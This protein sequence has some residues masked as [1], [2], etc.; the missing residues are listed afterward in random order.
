MRAVV[1]PGPADPDASP[2]VLLGQLQ[3]LIGEEAVARWFADLLAG[4]VRYDD[5]ELP[6]LGWF[7]TGAANELQRG[8]LEARGQDYWVRT[9]A[10]RGLLHGWSEGA[11]DVAVPAIVGALD[12]DAWRVREMA[13]KVVRRWRLHEAAAGVAALADDEVPRVRAA[14]A[15]ARSELADAGAA[16]IRR[17]GSRTTS[18]SAPTPAKRQPPAVATRAPITVDDLEAAVTDAVQV[19]RRG[20]DLDWSVPAGTLSWDCRRTCAHMADDL[21]AYAAQ[22]AAQ[23]SSGYLPFRLQPSRGT[24]PEGL[25]N[26]VE[27]TGAILAA[28]VRVAPEGAR[29][30]HPYGIADAEGFTALGIAEVILHTHDIAAGLG[31]AYEPAADVC[32]RV[33]SRLSRD[34]Q[35]RSESPWS[36][37]LWA[38]GRGDLPGREPVKRWRW[39][40]APAR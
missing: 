4:R 29:G 35:A 22:L 17:Q 40:P 33:L 14:A 30:F 25:L 9:W 32:E 7:G 1:I 26:L 23:V 28:T 3:E 27:A 21:I 16:P 38:T 31:L 37:L 8:D 24:S 39:W 36:V 6:P 11:A 19:L 5:P 2:A 13:A 18:R 12:D 10:A 34:P 15:R 20:V